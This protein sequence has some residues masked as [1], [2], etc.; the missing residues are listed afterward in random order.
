MDFLKEKEFEKNMITD[1]CN[2]LTTPISRL[3]INSINSSKSKTEENPQNMKY[4]KELF[5]SSAFSKNMNDNDNSKLISSLSSSSKNGSLNFDDSLSGNF[6]FPFIDN[7]ISR[8]TSDDIT[9]KNSLKHYKN[10]NNFRDMIFKSE[11]IR[12]YSAAEAT[13]REELEI[14][15]E[16][17]I[18]KKD[19]LK[20]RNRVSAKR[21]RAKKKEYIKMLENLLSKTKK[22]K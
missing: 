5:E 18:D 4:T 6:L 11:K 12:K 2:E 20:V 22:K 1:T 19:L 13:K 14:I 9:A 15:N 17:E 10:N 8:K 7:K 21:S 3:R 16:G